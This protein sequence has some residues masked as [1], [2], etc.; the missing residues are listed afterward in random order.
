MIAGRGP[1]RDHGCHGVVDRDQDVRSLGVEA[2]VARLRP[3]IVPLGCLPF[4]K[5]R[6][7]IAMRAEAEHVRV[8]QRPRRSIVDLPY[9]A[10]KGFEPADEVIARCA[11][12]FGEGGHCDCSSQIMARWMM[13]STAFSMS[14]TLTH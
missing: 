10:R 3:H 13:V 9:V 1:W 12:G 5:T 2:E 7:H 11:V 14:C 8:K 6:D 4:G